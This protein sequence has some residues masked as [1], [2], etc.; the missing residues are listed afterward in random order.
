MVKDKINYRARGRNQGL[1]KQPV[2]GRA[3]DG[4]LR[5]GEME[6]DGVIGHGASNFLK[7]SMMT[8]GD[9]YKIAVCNNTGTLAAY[10]HS[11][12]ILISLFA[13]GVKFSR[14]KFNEIKLDKVTKFGRSFSLV[15]IPYCL[16]LLIQELQVMGIQTRLITEDNVNQIENMSYSNNFKINARDIEDS[17]FKLTEIRQLLIQYGFIDRQNAVSRQNIRVEKEDDIYFEKVEDYDLHEFDEPEEDNK[18]TLLPE[19]PPYAPDSPDYAPGSPGY[20][21]G[22]PA[23]NLDS[24]PW[25]PESQGYDIT[26]DVNFTPRIDD[27]EFEKFKGEYIKKYPDSHYGEHVVAYERYKVDG[28]LIDPENIPEE[29]IKYGPTLDDIDRYAA[30]HQQGG[31]IKM[32]IGGS[33][34]NLIKVSETNLTFEGGS[35]LQPDN[36]VGKETKKKTKELEKRNK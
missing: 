4:G 14:G 8:R 22:S 18:D 16:K 12:N 20:A 26:N 34:D 1:T 3:N 35:I 11:Q 6:R 28:Q 15:E 5:I 21:P 23:Y 31:K 36:V 17:N 32:N 19:S 24:P 9:D 7:E 29:E 25:A 33:N 27:D 13:D 30:T 10:N 2:S